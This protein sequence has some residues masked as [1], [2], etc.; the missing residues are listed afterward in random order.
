MKYLS[1]YSFLERCQSGLSQRLISL[2]LRMGW[3]RHKWSLREKPFTPLGVPGFCQ[4][5]PYGRIPVSPQMFYTYITKSHIDGIYY[6]GFTS[7][8]KTRLQYINSGKS[9]FTKT[10]KPQALHYFESFPKKKEAIKRELFFKS[11]D[12]YHGLAT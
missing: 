1:L 7:D 2:R 8:L 10:H 12:G 9:R 5:H 11:V 6:Y 4:R 3:S